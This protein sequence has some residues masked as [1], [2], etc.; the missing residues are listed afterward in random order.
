[1]LV[2][3]RNRMQTSPSSTGRQV[4]QAVRLATYSQD[5]TSQRLAAQAPS[6]ATVS[7]RSMC[8]QEVFRSLVM[9]ENIR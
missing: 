2:N 9:A 3:R 8:P 7:G 1:M 5:H 6:S 4:R